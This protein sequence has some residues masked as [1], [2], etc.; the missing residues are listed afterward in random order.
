MRLHA[1]LTL[2][3]VFA[4]STAACGGR[5]RSA[6]DWQHK[7]T[8]A[9]GTVL[10]HVPGECAAGH[11][12]LDLPAVEK[13]EASAAAVDVLSARFF[14]GMATTPSDRRV[15]TALRD[16]LREEG[17]DVVRDTKE[18]AICLRGAGG[19]VAVFGGDYSGKDVF[20]AF[21][22]AA[23][24]LGDKPP[25]IEND[26]GIEYI[27]LGQL[28]VARVAPNVVAIGEDLSAMI[29]LGDAADRS[30]QWGYKPGLVGFA[31]LAG[32][33][34]MFISFADKGEDVEIELILRASGSAKDYEGK[35]EGVADRLGDTPLKALAPAARA[36]QINTAA[37]FVRF[38]L[39]GK[40][41]DI[42]QAIHTAAELSPAELKKILGHVFSGTESGGPEHKI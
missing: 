14:A 4:T 39:R 38:L 36:A 5:A 11:V 7:A 33:D 21:E 15:L 41:R 1:R 20:H 42:A 8:F 10:K 18:I 2:L 27:A 26:K 37:G 9:R 12:F 16:S 35:R 32:E 23:K 40:S 25:K 24:K 17:L 6:I 28:R 13:N 30:E 3:A 31:R 22:T 29:M 19:V 34:E